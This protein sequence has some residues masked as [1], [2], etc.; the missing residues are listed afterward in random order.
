MCSERPASCSDR[1][2]KSKSPFF[3]A[4]LPASTLGSVYHPGNPSNCHGN[5][6]ASAETHSLIKDSLLYLI[7]YHYYYFSDISDSFLP[8]IYMNGMLTH[9]CSKSDC[10]EHLGRMFVVCASLSFLVTSMS[11]L[12]ERQRDLCVSV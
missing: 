5:L 8:Y 7:V 1:S 9:R 6:S 4:F 10:W 2:Y 3:F 11:V 12:R